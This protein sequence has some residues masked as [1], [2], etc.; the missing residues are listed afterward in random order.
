L[1]HK[2]VSHLGGIEKPLALVI[3]HYQRITRIAGRVAAYD[4]LL[5]SVDLVLDPCAGPLAG[6]VD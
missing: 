6:F 2:A 4:K 3:A 1:R 5:P